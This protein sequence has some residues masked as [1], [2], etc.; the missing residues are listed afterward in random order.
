MSLK[1]L[2]LVYMKAIITFCLFFAC[3]TQGATG[4]SQTINDNDMKKNVYYCEYCG[5]SF[6]ACALSH[7][8]LA[9]VIPMV[10][11]KAATSYTKAL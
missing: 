1:I 3:L 11:T 6:P 9:L 5:H 4:E 2:N 8:A 10:P 7:R